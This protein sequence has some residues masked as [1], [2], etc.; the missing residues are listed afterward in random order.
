MELALEAGADDV[1]SEGDS[2]EV[3]CPVEAFN[4]LCEAID[5][6]GLTTEVREITRIPKDIQARLQA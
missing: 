4:D 6:A 2:Y 1:K 5:K 3:T